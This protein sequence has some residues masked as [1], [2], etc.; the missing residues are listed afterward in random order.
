MPAEQKK[1]RKG[2]RKLVERE[3]RRGER[4]KYAIMVIQKLFFLFI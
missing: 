1:E 2:R 3:K 4:I